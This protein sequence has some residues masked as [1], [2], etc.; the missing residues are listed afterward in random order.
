MSYARSPR[1]LCSITIGTRPRSCVSIRSRGNVMEEAVMVET[2]Y[3]AMES[4]RDD[5]LV[6]RAAGA[7]VATACVGR[8]DL[9]A[10]GAP[11]SI[12]W[13]SAR[14]THQCSE[15]R[16]RILD[17]GL[18]EDPVDDVLFDCQRFEFVQA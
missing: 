18:T 7:R 15:G 10:D 14:R 9:P 1:P 5:A 4:G 8:I 13:S 2:S 6:R 3:M 12:A 11:S 17:P 16:G